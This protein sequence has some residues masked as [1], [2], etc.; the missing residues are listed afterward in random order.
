MMRENFTFTGEEGLQIYGY[1]WL[2][3][4]IEEAK[5]II[6]I[7]HGM[8]EGAHRYEPLAKYLTN[9][10]YIVYA[11][12]HRGHGQTGD[13]V[14]QIGILAKEN[15]FEYLVRDLHKLS[16]MIRKDYPQLP[17]ILLGHSM[18]SFVAQRY[19]MEYGNEIEGLILSG[20]NGKQGIL[21][22]IGLWMV[23]KEVEK[24]GRNTPSKK[25]DKLIFGTYNKQFGATRTPFDWL[26]R[27]EK[28]VDKYIEDPYCGGVFSAGFFYDFLTGL[29]YIGKLENKKSIPVTLPIY[30]FSGD[31]DPVGKNGKGILDLV[32]DYKKVGI[33]KVEYKL[34]PGGRHEMLNEVNKEE[35]MKDILGWVEEICVQS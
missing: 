9:H 3:E 31:R 23:K 17:L 2:P 8:A 1:K 5:G 21:L 15:G 6:Q 14:G 25:L 28:E 11:H 20:S 7:S 30:I 26:S 18:G 12:D 24:I 27:D 22:D 35:V 29:K 33:Q 34:Y 16:Q 10:G 19:I 13:K 4:N 32:K